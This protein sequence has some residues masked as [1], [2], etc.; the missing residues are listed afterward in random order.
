MF[1]RSLFLFMIAFSSLFSI[2]PPEKKEGLL[3]ITGCARSGTRYIAFMMCECGLEFGHEWF[4]KDGL[5]SWPM[6]VDS[7]K[8]PWGHPSNNYNFKHVFHQVR[9]PLKVISSVYAWEPEASWEFIKRYVPEINDSDTRLVMT[10]KYWYY[11][12]LLAEQKSDFTYRV[13][14]ID[15]ALD[16]MSLRLDMELD[17]S[18]IYTVSKNVNTRGPVFEVTWDLLRTSL[19]E[20]LYRDILL[21]SLRYGYV[22]ED[23]D[24]RRLLHLE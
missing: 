11:W 7:D 3:L 24:M 23:S 20:G 22:I 9:H 17:K 6:A 1:N 15:N 12:N 19:P 16:E 5:S 8:V 13:E 10:A 2:A 4:H 14:D 21:M 18:K